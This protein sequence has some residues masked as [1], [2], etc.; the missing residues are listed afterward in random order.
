MEFSVALCTYNGERFL[1][2]QLQSIAAQTRLPDELVVCDDKSG[3]D[4]PRIVR[5]FAGA[6]PFPVHLHLN[7]V[8]L[9]SNRNFER[10]IGLCAGELIALCDQDDIWRADKLEQL[11]R[12]F[13]KH[14]RAAS[15]FSDAI[16]VDDA[17]Q[18][19]PPNLWPAVGLTRAVQERL[20]GPQ[21]FATLLSRTPVT[22]ATLAFRARYRPLITPIDEGGPLIHDGWIAVLLA[23][24][25][26]TVALPETLIFYRRHAEQ[27][28]H[29]AGEGP[30]IR[31]TDFYRSHLRQLKVMRLRLAEAGGA[32]DEGDL[33]THLAILDE[34]IAHLENRLALPANRAARG[35]R[36]GRELLSGRY[37][38]HSSGWRSALRDL[39]F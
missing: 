36:V 5:D 11:E 39:V 23:G 20:G 25:A 1:L 16:V 12:A 14:P 34:K 37:R 33:P 26:P 31:T 3:D 35:F 28:T 7:E 24:V 6:A 22:G 10:A 30:L 29:G 32:F 9:G 13:E 17:D 8:N 15:V 18:P 2:R 4:T 38:R 19:F 21:A 27:Q